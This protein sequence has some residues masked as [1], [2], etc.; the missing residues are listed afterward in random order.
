MT[1]PSL[2]VDIAAIKDDLVEMDV[3]VTALENAPDPEP[4][5]DILARFVGTNTALT[6]EDAG[7]FI[8][9]T[10]FSAV[11]VAL[12][13][14]IIPAGS[15]VTLMKISSGRVIIVPD[16]G[17]SLNGSSGTMII[18]RTNEAVVIRYTGDDEYSI[19]SRSHTFSNGF[20]I[21]TEGT[22]IT[23]EDAG[24][25]IVA[26]AGLDVYVGASSLSPGQS[27][28]ILTSTDDLVGFV[29]DGG[30]F[31]NDPTVL[32]LKGRGSA[33][34]VTRGTDNLYYVYT[35]A[36]MPETMI[37]ALRTITGN[38]AIV[39]SDMGKTLLVNSGSAISLD[40]NANVIP[41][42]GYVH[43]LRQGMGDV[44]VNPGPGVTINGS[45]SD[46]TFSQQWVEKTL[47]C[48][49]PNEFAV[50]K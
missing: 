22:N 26:G 6:A 11:T 17:V 2:P 42:G 36:P 15:E 5:P 1:A 12:G 40:L 23:P 47:L 25:T 37:R 44:H 27:V 35:S 7:G 8:G 31:A 29:E 46:I 34:V 16:S 21:A 45:T 50:I 48:I 18:P 41:V 24:G 13:S 4:A 43:I 3:R 28:T 38:D 9:F 19:V 49:A 32:R 20:R 10:N 33:A 14:D 39:T 30:I